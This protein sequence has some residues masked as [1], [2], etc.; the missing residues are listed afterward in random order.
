ML[1][2]HNAKRQDVI[3]STEVLRRLQPEVTVFALLLGIIGR[4]YRVRKELMAI[5]CPQKLSSYPNAFVNLPCTLVLFGSFVEA[6]VKGLVGVAFVSSKE[7][8]KV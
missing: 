2:K 5:K 3:P 7:G 4:K 1:L 6:F 8:H